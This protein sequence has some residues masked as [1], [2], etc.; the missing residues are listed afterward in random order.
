MTIN[1]PFIFVTSFISKKS[2]CLKASAWLELAV[3]LYQ[4]PSTFKSKLNELLVVNFLDLETTHLI[5]IRK[6]FS[7]YLNFKN[8]KV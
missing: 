7:F 3:Y 8:D 5:V 6:K 1:L 2:P 4:S